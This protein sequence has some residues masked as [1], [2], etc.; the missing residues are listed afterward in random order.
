M[1]LRKQ[2]FVVSSELEKQQKELRGF[3]GSWSQMDQRVAR[4]VADGSPALDARWCELSKE[5][6]QTSRKKSFM[7]KN[8]HTVWPI[9]SP[10]LVT[11]PVQCSPFI[12]GRCNRSRRNVVDNKN[13]RDNGTRSADGKEKGPNSLPKTGLVFTAQKWST[14][15]RK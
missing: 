4:R 6:K 13:L 10:T 7:M 5:K 14:R 3:C 11:S 2:L 15:G 8:T 9:A 12:V 1:T